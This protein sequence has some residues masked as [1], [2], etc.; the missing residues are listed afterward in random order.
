MKN[1]GTLR[2]AIYAKTDRLKEKEAERQKRDR[3]EGRDKKINV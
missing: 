1:M 3:K 2:T